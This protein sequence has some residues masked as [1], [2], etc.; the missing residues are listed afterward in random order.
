MAA[1]PILTAMRVL[2]GF[3]TAKDYNG[4]VFRLF[5]TLGI[6]F[7]GSFV[8]GNILR[9][10]A[11]DESV[12][13]FRS[14]AFCVPNIVSTTTGILL[15]KHI[16]K[17]EDNLTFCF[18]FMHLVIFLFVGILVLRIHTVWI[19]LAA[20]L[21][22]GPILLSQ[23]ENFR[24][25]TVFLIWA[26]SILLIMSSVVLHKVE[27]ACYL[28]R[29]QHG[30]Q[31]RSPLGLY[32]PLLLT[33]YEPRDR[34]LYSIYAQRRQ[35]IGLCFHVGFEAVA[36]IAW[37][38]MSCL[39]A[40]LQRQGLMHTGYRSA[41][42]MV[43]SFQGTAWGAATTGTGVLAVVGLAVFHERILWSHQFARIFALVFFMVT[44]FLNTLSEIEILS[45]GL[46]GN[47][48]RFTESL[49]RVSLHIFSACALAW[50]PFWAVFVGQ[51]LRIGAQLVFTPLWESE[52]AMMFVL[53]QISPL[54]VT[55]IHERCRVEKFAQNKA[56]L[57]D[58]EEQDSNDGKSRQISIF[59]WI[60]VVIASLGWYMWGPY[61]QWRALISEQ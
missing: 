35:F 4:A 33:F 30:H 14:I 41:A 11:S 61:M 52:V 42:L 3:A 36:H 20:M 27:A 50:V 58:V 31:H 6:V 56:P 7:L 26:T 16:A 12:R 45:S 59:V 24:C 19:A 51:V 13:R 47:E 39:S 54:C 28:D 34:R 46:G 38:A 25:A 43:L 17:G 37:G 44:Q 32:N 60:I 40:S 53:Y 57:V 10:G 18:H 55:Y 21:Q 9:G 15:S 48:W 49:C 8:V 2:I 29:L 22:M 5:S 1:V 23:L